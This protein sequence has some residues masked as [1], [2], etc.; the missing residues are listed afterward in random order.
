MMHLLLLLLLLLLGLILTLLWV[1]VGM[2]VSTISTAAQRWWRCRMLQ[3]WRC[4]LRL[5]MGSLL[6]RRTYIRWRRSCCRHIVAFVFTIRNCDDSRWR[7]CVM[8]GYRLLLNNGTMMLM[9]VLRLRVMWG[10]VMLT[11]RRWRR[12]V[13][14]ITTAAIIS[15]WCTNSTAIVYNVMVTAASINWICADDMRL[16]VGRRS[17]M[18]V[19]ATDNVCK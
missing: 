11:A 12:R 1:R 10:N 14:M 6:S 15:R 3:H 5:S 18:V 7:W 17:V 13:V 16:V 8:Y 9:S 2:L 19:T 4:G